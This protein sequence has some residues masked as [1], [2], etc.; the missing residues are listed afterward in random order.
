MQLVELFVDVLHKETTRAD[1]E[2]LSAR[3]LF[4]AI[5]GVDGVNTD[6]EEITGILQYLTNP[7]L[8]VLAEQSGGY[9]LTAR[10]DTSGLRLSALTSAVTGQ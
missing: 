9:M 2:A 6:K 4:L 5:R 1:G 3:D 8:R 10:R 7:L